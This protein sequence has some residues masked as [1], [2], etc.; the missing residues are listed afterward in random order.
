M[1]VDDPDLEKVRRITGQ[2][3]MLAQELARV[4]LAHWQAPVA[5][6]LNGYLAL[7]E[8][9]EADFAEAGLGCVLDD[10]ALLGPP[11]SDEDF[12]DLL[13]RSPLL[14]WSVKLAGNACGIRAAHPGRVPRRSP[15]SRPADRLAGSAR[16]ASDT[17][18]TAHLA[19]G[20]SASGARW[21]RSVSRFLP[22]G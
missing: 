7:D 10:L 21:T 9:A 20:R 14:G 22:Q 1:P 13:M 19:V 6:L 15:R 8:Y 3:L 2:T 4:G 11:L 16:T 12:V 18:R 5:P 17:R